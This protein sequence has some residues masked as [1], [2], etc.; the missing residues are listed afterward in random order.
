MERLTKTYPVASFKK[1]PDENGKTGRFEA[2]VS[3]FGNVDLQGDRVQPGAFSKS[4]SNWR[5]K[6]DPIPAIWSHDWANP[7][8]HFGYSDPNDV[9]EVTSSGKAG[10]IE[11]GLRVIG[12]ADVGPGGAALPGKEFAKQVYDLLDERRVTEWSF[13]YDVIREQRAADKA[14][15]LLELGLIEYGPTL[16]GANPDT[17]TIG[18]KAAT[19]I[20]ERADRE[21]RA[22]S[23][24]E[25]RIINLAK[26]ADDYGDSELATMVRAQLPSEDAEKDEE[27][28]RVKNFYGAPAGSA[29]ERADYVRTAVNAWADTTYP[30]DAEG[31]RQY[32]CVI[33]TYPDHV[34][35]AIEAFDKDPEYLSL[36]YTVESDGETVLLGEPSAVDVEVTVTPAAAETGTASAELTLEGVLADLKMR[37]LEEVVE[38]LKAGR[39]IGAS[40]ATALK[41][42]LADAVDTFVSEVN[43]AT[44]GAAAGTTDGA[45]SSAPPTDDAPPPPVDPPGE[46][47]ESVR[48]ELLRQRIKML[49]ASCA[50]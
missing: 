34:V 50:L 13:A 22:I 48:M 24:T 45:K 37:N 28:A 29:E 20:G 17:F 30:P 21:H 33:G 11:G 15:D 9:E 49:D 44:D 47:P 32:A 46:T 19:L 42:A 39:V 41:T 43:G 31:D 35:V 7:F 4:I 36:P 25:Q 23:E 40:R 27:P 5:A 14:N 6:G 12:Q 8:A 10:T 26:R 3:V 16:K 1:L 38:N 2:V 18:V